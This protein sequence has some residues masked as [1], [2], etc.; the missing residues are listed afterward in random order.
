M[1]IGVMVPQG[2]LGEY[3]GWDP[4]RAWERTL[5]VARQAE[6]LGFESVWV[7]DHL[8]TAPDVRDE[9]TFES[10]ASLSAIA[11]STNRVRLG[12]GGRPERSGDT[13]MAR[14]PR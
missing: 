7:V 8:H 1:R 13:G 6:R 5:A 4:V 12:H 11:A 14:L 3:P 9:I 10:F 2:W